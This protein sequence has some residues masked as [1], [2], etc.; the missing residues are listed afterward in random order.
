MYICMCRS[1][2]EGE[3]T[4]RVYEIYSLIAVEVYPIYTSISLQEE[5]GYTQVNSFYILK[6]IPAK[7]IEREIRLRVYYVYID[8]H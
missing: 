7:E 8:V 2:R 4:E 3:N 5:E 6:Y 1:E